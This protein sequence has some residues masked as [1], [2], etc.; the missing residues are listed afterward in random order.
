MPRIAAENIEEHLRQQTERIL[1]AARWSFMENG[2]R[3]T[4]LG[5]IA[6]KTGL[7]RNSLYRYFRSKDHILVA[8]MEREMAPFAA[9]SETLERDFPDPEQR[10]D[11]WLDLQMELATGPCHSM[12]AMLGDMTEASDDLRRKIASLHVGPQV[13][14]EKA[15]AE[16]LEGSDRDPRI[17]SGMIAGMLQSAG[18][19]A[20]NSDDPD[21][22]IAELKKSV[23]NVLALGDGHDN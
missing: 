4:G 9:R 17:V 18:G 21:G 7:A 5:R 2:Y 8:V 3:A 14:L 15:V 19:A 1:D 23:G 13:T 10:I 11:A 6:R 22:V 12:I 20:M 16:L